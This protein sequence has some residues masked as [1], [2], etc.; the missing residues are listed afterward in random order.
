METINNKQ[1]NY[2][3]IIPAEIRYADIP[4]NAKLLYGE[5]TAL[6][7]KQGFCFATNKYFAELYGVHRDTIS[8]WISELVKIRAVRLEIKKGEI[9]RIYLGVSAKSPRGIGEITEGGIGEITEHN[10][11]STNITNNKDMSNNI[12]ELKFIHSEICKLFNK[13]ESRY[14]L[15]DKRKQKLKSRLKDLGKEGILQACEAITRSDFHMGENQRN[16]IAEPYWALENFERAEKWAGEY[17]N[18]NKYADLT[19]LEF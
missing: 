15:S 18:N 5:I 17:Q 11:T 3:A 14:K 4:A 19:K 8:K 10:N 2:Y 12:D 13:S 6:A 9:R 7:N 1:P 16:W